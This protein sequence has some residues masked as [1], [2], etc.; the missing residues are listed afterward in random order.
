M[1]TRKTCLKHFH[2][3]KSVQ[4]RNFFWSVFSCI[5]TESVQTREN[6][7]QEKLR[8]WTFFAQYFFR[9]VVIYPDLI[10][11]EALLNICHRVFLQK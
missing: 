5:W 1:E 4:T 10:C 6:E 11:N 7:D 8:I 3:V 2:C 9:F